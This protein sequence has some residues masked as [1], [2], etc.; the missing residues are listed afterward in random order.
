M[1][2]ACKNCRWFDRAS[3]SAREKFIYRAYLD[4]KKAYEDDVEK[5]NS[6]SFLAVVF[7]SPSDMAS[8]PY[9]PYP[10]KNPDTY[11]WCR[12]EPV[13]I[14]KGNDERCSHFEASK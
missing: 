6:R 7:M 12:K 4:S 3:S 9:P 2:D 10:V 1:S 14:E 13:S 8:L 11:G 5:R